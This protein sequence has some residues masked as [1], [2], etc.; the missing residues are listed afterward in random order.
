MQIIFPDHNAVGGGKERINLKK[1][2]EPK[3]VKLYEP[4]D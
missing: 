2:A 3:P 4:V 1:K